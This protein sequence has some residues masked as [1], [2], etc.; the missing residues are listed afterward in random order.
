MMIRLDSKV[1]SIS[2]IPQQFLK[3]INSYTSPIDDILSDL[4]HNPLVN[5]I[6]KNVY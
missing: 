6:V 5:E 3:R 1:L 4:V 2:S